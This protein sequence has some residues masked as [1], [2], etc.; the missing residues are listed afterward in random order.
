MVCTRLLSRSMRVHVLD[1]SAYTPPYDHALCRALGEA[2]VQVELF[3]SRFAY[4]RAPAPVSYTRREFF[5]RRSHAPTRVGAR[6]RAGLAL[7]LAEHLPDMLRYRRASQQ[8]EL[9]H[10]QFNG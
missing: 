9:V 7:K 1:P 5:Y 10:F 6:S 4:G 3:T 2:G 8:A